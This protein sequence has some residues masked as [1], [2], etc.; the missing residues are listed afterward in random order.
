M[1]KFENLL[2]RVVERNAS[3][4]T[5]TQSR[6]TNGVRADCMRID[7]ACYIDSLLYFIRTKY[8]LQGHE[9]CACDLWYVSINLYIPWLAFANECFCGTVAA[10]EEHEQRVFSAFEEDA[11]MRKKSK[12]CPVEFVSGAFRAWGGEC[13]GRVDIPQ[14]KRF[15]RRASGVHEDCARADAQG[16]GVVA[17]VDVEAEQPVHT[18]RVVSSGGRLSRAVRIARV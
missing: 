3:K 5:R 2:A 16:A 1:V 6:K 15:G 4:Q 8:L 11:R 7:N 9:A 18:A 10:A 14:S 12:S 13:D 17:S